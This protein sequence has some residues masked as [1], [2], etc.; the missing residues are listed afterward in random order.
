[1][2]TDNIPL[3]ENRLE[4]RDTFEGRLATWFE[5]SEWDLR[6]VQLKGKGYGMIASNDIDKGSVVMS[7]PPYVFVPYETRKK[8]VCAY[9]FKMFAPDPEGIDKTQDMTSPPSTQGVN[10]KTD[11]N[12][13]DKTDQNKDSTDK[14]ED[15]KANTNSNAGEQA[16]NKE[17]TSAPEESSEARPC[18]FCVEVTLFFFLFMLLRIECYFACR[19]GTAVIY[20]KTL[21]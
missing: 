12:K 5:Q 2:T 13:D 21:I 1:M 8:N 20:V 7:C 19:F 10:D 15:N 3:P 4:G 6:L 9:C 11:Q 17:A 16:E 18:Q 14:T